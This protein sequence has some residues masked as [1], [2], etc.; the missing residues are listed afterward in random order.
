[1]SVGCALLALAAAMV[2]TCLGVVVV[3]LM[4]INWPRQ[5]VAPL[6]SHEESEL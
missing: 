4:L 6:P 3:C 2:G 1:V 5:P